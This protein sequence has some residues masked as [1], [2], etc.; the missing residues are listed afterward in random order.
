MIELHKATSERLSASPARYRKMFA[1]LYK[2]SSAAYATV[3]HSGDIRPKDIDKIAQR[4]ALL[5]ET[6][7]YLQDM[8][9]SLW[10]FWNICRYDER[11]M[12]YWAGIINEE[13]IILAGVVR[14]EEKPRL[15][16]I[17]NWHSVQEAC[18]LDTMSNLHRFT[19]QKVVHAPQR[20]YDYV[21]AEIIRCVDDA[22]C[23]LL[24]GNRIRAETQAEADMRL[25]Y[26]EQAKTRL[27]DMQR[28]LY[29]LWN[30]EQY[31]ER[32]MDQWA[33]LIDAELKLINGL[34]K[35]E[36]TRSNTLS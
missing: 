9:G 23:S 11:R 21:S 22:W 6:V 13:L 15:I 28:P 1:E 10:C 32:E 30:V 2:Q 20:Y 36:K 5:E 7:K 31:S 35:S 34:M 18:F 3:I 25:E 19:Y 14:R 4:D 16:D 17:I 29:A 33:G 27:N 8:Q 12:S 24:Q 26:F